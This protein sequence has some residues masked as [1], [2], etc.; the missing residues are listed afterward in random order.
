MYPNSNELI[1]DLCLIFSRIYKHI[2]LKPGPFLNLIIGPNGSGKSAIVCAIIIGFGGDPQ[3]TGRSSALIDY[4]RF[5][6]Q[7]AE[8]AIE[9]NS[10]SED[11]ENY[12][13]QRI[14]RSTLRNGKKDCSTTW[15]LN[16]DMV[17][18]ARI[19]KFISDLH[20]DI[21]NLCQVLPQERVVEFAKMSPKQLLVST[22]KSIGDVDM[23]DRHMKLISLS[24][25]ISEL[26]E[27]IKDC[28]AFIMK[29]Q[30][31]KVNILG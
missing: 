13:I 30:N 16:G 19:L 29:Y 23:Y 27:K 5:G 26:Q 18:K 21:N 17:D 6:S 4:I 28:N 15:K 14:L 7:T 25:K 20:I 3:I 8:I 9:I 31:F 24:E 22:E 12:L 10:G 1:L 2:E 11:E